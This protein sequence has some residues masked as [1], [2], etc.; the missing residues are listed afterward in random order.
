M[1]T[2]VAALTLVVAG[3]AA[4]GLPITGDGT[5][6]SG[7]TGGGGGI[8]TSFGD[9]ARLMGGTGAACK[10]AC[11]CASGLGCTSSGTC[12]AL[13]GQKIYCCD[14][15]ADC[16]AGNVCQSSTGGFGLCGS[17]VNPG[18]PPLFGD[19]SIPSDAGACAAI[20]CTTT[21]EC[22]KA[23]CMTCTRRGTCR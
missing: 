19:M 12:Q 22:V 3:C 21:N 17:G 15:A 13:P 10:T 14:D 7:G 18:G 20:M 8:I 2:L 23:G 4:Q 5:G 11:D 16:P 6:G 1:R 9:L